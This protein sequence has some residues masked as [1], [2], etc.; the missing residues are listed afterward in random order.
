[1]S[2]LVSTS[3]AGL[4]HGTGHCPSPAHRPS[5]WTDYHGAYSCQIIEIVSRLEDGLDVQQ[6][7]RRERHIS[8]VH[9]LTQP[10]SSNE[11]H[12]TSLAGM[13][14]LTLLSLLLFLF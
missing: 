13:V 10:P 6:W 2:A 11:I 3:A 12:L 14:L 1:L 7:R 5:A 9:V 4:S 8:I